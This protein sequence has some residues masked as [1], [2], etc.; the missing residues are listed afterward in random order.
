ME[1]QQEF[2]SINDALEWA[3]QRVEESARF[4]AELGARTS[5]AAKVAALNTGNYAAAVIRG[6]VRNDA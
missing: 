1:D 5:E 6:R 3:A 2:R 4:H